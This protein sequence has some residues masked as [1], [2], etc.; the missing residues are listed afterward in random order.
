MNTN[1]IKIALSFVF[2]TFSSFTCKEG[3]KIDKINKITFHYVD[4]EI[5]TPFQV[6][7][8]NFETLFSGTYK[9]S[10]ISNKS[11]LEE[12]G[13]YL[14]HCDVLDTAKAID[15]RVKVLITYANKKMSI[16]CMDKFNNLVLENKSISP[17]KD[18]IA[19][20]RQQLDN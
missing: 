6:S 8:N 5:E 7:C 9:T 19:F 10:D 1:R 2:F 16:L 11:K 20:M 13:N 3:Q 15:T 18:I 14:S 12:F 17:N 4:L